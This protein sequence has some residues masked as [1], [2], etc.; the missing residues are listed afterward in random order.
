[1]CIFTFGFDC[2]GIFNIGIGAVFDVNTVSISSGNVYCTGFFIDD[3]IFALTI[4]TVS[5]AGFARNGNIA[6]IDRFTAFFYINTG[7]GSA[8]FIGD[9]NRGT[10]AIIYVASVRGFDADGF[11]GRAVNDVDFTTFA[12]C[13]IGF[14]FKV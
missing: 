9:V 13:G 8:I 7:C 10:L 6:F 4:D 14:I 3:G 12:C 5:R 11:A 2:T 1:M